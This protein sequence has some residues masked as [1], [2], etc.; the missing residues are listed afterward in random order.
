MLDLIPIGSKDALELP[1]HDFFPSVT[2]CPFA[3]KLTMGSVMLVNPNYTFTQAIEELSV[4]PV[5]YNS[6]YNVT[7]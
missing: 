3:D 2:I 4:K 7:K 6:F 1:K 5:V